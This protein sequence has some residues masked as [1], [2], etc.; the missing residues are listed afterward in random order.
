MTALEP[1]NTTQLNAQPERVAFTDS[2]IVQNKPSKP[3][4]Q[5]I[6]EITEVNLG[7]L[8]SFP[9]Q[10]DIVALGTVSS[11]GWSNP[12]LVPYT[13]VQAPPDGI[14]DFDF[15]ATPPQEKAAQVITPIRVKYVWKAFPRDLKGVRVHASTNSKVALLHAEVPPSESAK[16]TSLT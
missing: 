10:L 5:S 11:A 14:Y 16:S 3:T 13:Y 15:V 7:V 12:Q 8:K 9:S 6:L 2:T 4:Q 1:V